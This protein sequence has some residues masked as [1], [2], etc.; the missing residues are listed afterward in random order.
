MSAIRL[1]FIAFESILPNSSKSVSPFA[2]ED[3]EKSHGKLTVSTSEPAE[4]LEQLE[5][6]LRREQS[7]TAT[8]LVSGSSMAGKV[9]RVSRVIHIECMAP[10]CSPTFK[11]FGN[12]A[13][14]PTPLKHSCYSE[15]TNSIFLTRQSRPQPMSCIIAHVLLP[16]NTRLH[17]LKTNTPSSLKPHSRTFWL[18]TPREFASMDSSASSATLCSQPMTLLSS[19]DVASAVTK[20]S[21]YH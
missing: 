8:K 2:F 15:A 20:V 4:K 16:M 3:G 21:L 14:A 5:K 10:L 18:P 1:L 12:L 19:A 6:A 11:L 9:R 17:S 13:A 7:Q